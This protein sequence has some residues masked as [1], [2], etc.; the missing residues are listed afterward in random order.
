M[1]HG[2]LP[3]APNDAS[4]VATVQEVDHSLA[5]RRVYRVQ[6][7]GETWTGNNRGG[8]LRQRMFIPPNYVLRNPIVTFI[9]GRTGAPA[10][11][12]GLDI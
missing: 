10:V 4:M 2:L 11:F 9:K 1:D 12:A 3:V 7:V 5:L 8:R 6:R